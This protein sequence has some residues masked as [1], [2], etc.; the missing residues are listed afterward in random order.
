MHVVRRRRRRY[1]LYSFKSEKPT[2]K[3]RI[4][5]IETFQHHQY[6]QQRL[7]SPGGGV[8]Y[9]VAVQDN[10]PEEMLAMMRERGLTAEVW[11]R[12]GTVEGFCDSVQR[13]G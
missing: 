3:N 4:S 1:A 2:R 5:P 6:Q 13:F 7:L 12:E 10:R 9:L 8:M 11:K